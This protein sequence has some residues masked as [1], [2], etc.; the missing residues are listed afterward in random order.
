MKFSKIENNTLTIYPNSCLTPAMYFREHVKKIVFKSGVKEIPYGAFSGLNGLKCVELNYDLKKI[1]EKAFST[2][3]ELEYI[4]IPESVEEMG[5]NVFYQCSALDTIACSESLY[6]KR[7]TW[8][9]HNPGTNA[10]IV[11][12]TQ[13]GSAKAVHLFGSSFSC[14]ATGKRKHDRIFEE[15]KKILAERGIRTEEEK[16]YETNYKNYK[17]RRNRQLDYGIKNRSKDISNDNSEE[18]ETI[19]R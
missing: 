11:Y 17:N 19:C 13:K 2:N 18:I 10:I 16:I 3:F 1:S 14:D 6:N 8:L 9:G 12:N 15:V 7:E 4:I 5:K